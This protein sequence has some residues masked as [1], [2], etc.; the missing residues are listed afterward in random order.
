MKLSEPASAKGNE[1]SVEEPESGRGPVLQAKSIR[2]SREQGEAQIERQDRRMRFAEEE[3]AK[4][5]RAQRTDM[6]DV[7]NGLE[8]VRTG[9]G[10]GGLAPGSE[11]DQRKRERKSVRGT[12][13]TWRKGRQKSQR[14]SA[15]REDVEGEEEQEADDDEVEKEKIWSED[16][17]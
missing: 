10:S 2:S 13:R 12:K 7:M 5:S 8:E 1:Q 4:E 6:Q 11:R 17:C 15:E 16:E 9:R 3:Q 14:I